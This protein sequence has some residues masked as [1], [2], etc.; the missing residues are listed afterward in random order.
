L[1]KIAIRFKAK[2]FL[3]CV[4]INNIQTESAKIFSQKGNSL[5]YK[6][7]FLKSVYWNKIIN[8][9]MARC[10]LGSSYHFK[11]A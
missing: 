11:K 3:I 10:K 9:Y 7:R 6:I 4:I 1:A 8:I 5:D 2:N